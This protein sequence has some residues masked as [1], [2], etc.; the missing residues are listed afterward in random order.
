M[1]KENE[2]LTSNELVLNAKNDEAVYK[3]FA[4]RVEAART[5]ATAAKPSTKGGG[6]RKR[7]SKKSAAAAAS[8]EDLPENDAQLTADVALGTVLKAIRDGKT[9]RKRIAR[10]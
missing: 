5:A 7:A 2:V 3:A 6:G 9:K 8:K 10:T 4:S 1:G